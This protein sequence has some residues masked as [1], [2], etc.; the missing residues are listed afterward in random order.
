MPDFNLSNTFQLFTADGKVILNKKLNSTSE[1]IQINHLSKGIYF[2]EILEKKNIVK[3][4]KIIL[5]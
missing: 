3:K 5:E 4:G 1:K 2:Y